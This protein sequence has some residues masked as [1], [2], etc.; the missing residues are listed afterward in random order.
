MLNNSNKKC[1]NEIILIIWGGI[2][3]IILSLKELKFH[4]RI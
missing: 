4:D 1:L 2:F 3:N